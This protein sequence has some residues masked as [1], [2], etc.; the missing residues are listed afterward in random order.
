MRTYNELYQEIRYAMLDSA[1]LKEIGMNRKDMELELNKE[2]WHTMAALIQQCAEVDGRFKSTKI[3]PAIKEAV[4]ALAEEPEEGWLQYC[5]SYTLSRLFPE[6][7]ETFCPRDQH[8]L[9]RL[10][11]LQIFHGVY[12]YEVLH[13]AYD[14]TKNMQ[15]L[16]AAEVTEKGFTSEYLKLRKMSKSLYLY[17]FMRIGIDITPFNTLGH[18]AGVHYVAMH[19]ARQLYDAGVP[20]DLAL[21]SGAAAGHDIGK[22]GCRKHE[23]KRIPYLHYYY[24]SEER[25]VGK[26]CR[27]RWSPYH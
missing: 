11:L 6:V 14:P 20:V 3:L 1:F 16:S 2:K 18:V 10:Y 17:E 26:E 12:R 9:G 24:R 8:R 19:A 7:N 27:S 15:F 25:R 22:Y 4:P 5:N 23:E 21:I 13:L